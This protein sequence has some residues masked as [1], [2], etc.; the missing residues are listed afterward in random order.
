MEKTALITGITGQDGPYLAALL[1]EKGYRVYGLRQPVAVPD[2]GRIEKILGGFEKTGRFFLRYGDLVDAGSVTRLIAEIQPNEIY[3]LA[4]QSHVHTS[5]DVPEMT[6]Q[7]NALGVLRILESIRILGLEK[8]VRF[9]QASTSELFGDSTPPQSEAT[10]MNPRSPYAAAKQYAYQTVKI[11][12]EAYGLHASNGIMF[13]HESPLRGEE[14]VTRKICRAVARIAAGEQK[15]LF[16]GNLEAERDWSHARDVVRGIH[17]IAR[18][19]RSGDFVL[20]SGTAHTV[21]E[22]AVEAFRVAGI[23]LGWQ[24]QGVDERAIDRA[25]GQTVI[26]VDPELFR[27][28]EVERLLGDPV[29]AWKRL[30][31]KTEISF[32]ELVREMVEAE[33]S[34]LKD[35]DEEPALVRLYA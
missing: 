8:A 33:F 11:Y 13:N 22:F 15:T 18:Q 1:L 4:A 28:L 26:R 31:W 9:F 6:A 24:G 30:G 10:P 21:R 25:T 19:D 32:L 23:D 20:A 12:R 7:V 35:R 3:N 14:F 34:L 5:F 2:L 27:P 16:L 29:Q 17:A